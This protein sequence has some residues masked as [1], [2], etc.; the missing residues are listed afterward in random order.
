MRMC[1]SARASHLPV[2]CGCVCLCVAMAAMG[3]LLNGNKHWLGD[4]LTLSRL[5]LILDRNL[6]GIAIC[7]LILMCTAPGWLGQ[8]L[9]H[10]L[11]S[12]FWYPLAQLSYS[13][14]LLHYMLAIPLLW[15]AIQLMKNVYGEA[16]VF[17]HHWFMAIFFVLLAL[18]LPISLLAYALVEKPFMNRRGPAVAEAGKTV[19]LPSA[20]Q[21]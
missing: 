19:N 7:W 14:Y 5:M 11:G 2:C 18:T 16:L 12:K 20:S 3:V 10:V 6:L 13:M 1:I 17:Q 21:S 15:A 9:N 8:L 4:S